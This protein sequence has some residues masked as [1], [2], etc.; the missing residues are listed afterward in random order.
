MKNNTLQTVK[1]NTL[2]VCGGTGAHVALALV[3]L[4]TL[5]HAL[6]F[7]RGADDQPLAFP[8]IYLV[9][10]DSGDG[11]REATAWQ[12]ARRLVDAHPGRHNWQEAIGRSD[13]PELKIVTPLPVGSNRSWFNPPFDTLGRRFAD[14]P[15]LD[16]LT[17]KAQRDVRFSHGMMGSPAVGS[18]LFRLKEFDTESSEAGTNH[19]GTYHKLLSTRGR[20]AVVGSAVG[21]TGASVAPTLA[22]RFAAAGDDVMAVMVLN[23][24][25]FDPEG[26]DEETLEKAQ[27]RDRSMVQ[28]ANSAF[29]YYGR[30]LAHRVAT[31]PVGMP[32]TV[33]KLRR[34]TSDTQQP[35]R[36]S[37]IHGVAALCGLH[38]FL[39]REPYSRGLYQMGAEDPTRL[40]GGNRLP[41]GEG[42]DTVQS[43]ANQAATLA[44]TLHVFAATLSAP[45][46]RGLFGVVP[47]IHEAAGRLAAPERVGRAVRDLAADYREHLKWMEEVLGVQPRPD[48]SLTSEARSRSRL[49][50]HKLPRTNRADISAEDSAALA[51]F[52]W[53]AHWIRDYS[54]VGDGR[55]ALVA[56][57]AL[58]V[59]GGYWPPL[60]GH[61]A[62]NVAAEKA[63][64]LTQVSD[65]DIDGTVEGFILEE[66]VS[67]NGWPDP[68]AAVDHFRYAIERGRRGH[69]TERRQLEMLLA[70]VVM[71]KLVLRD[72]PPRTSPPTL[73]LEQLVDESREGRLPDFAR[74]EVVYSP[75][76]GDVVLGFN[77]PYTLLCPVPT[78]ASDE[79][80]EGAWGALW[81]AL[82]GS[83]RPREWR[84][85][86]IGE[87][88]Y[89]GNAVRQI[90]A[91]I[92][93]EKRVRGGTPL[94]WTHVF[95]H[96]SV[97]PSAPFGRGR[98]LSVHW[99]ADAEAPIQIALPT[100]ESGNYWPDEDT[101]PI[102]EA[103]L[104]AQAPG[105]LTL[106]T[107]AGIT[108]DRV[109]FELPDRDAPVRAL[110][111]EHLEHLQQTGGIAAFG[112]KPDD[113]QVAFLTA[114]RRSAAILDN[115]I[116]LDRDDIMVRDCSPMRQEPV[117]GS[118]TTDGR[119]HYPDYPLR[120]DY[121]GL[122]ETDE[123]RRVVDL[124]KHGEQVRAAQPS[125]DEGPRRQSTDER[126]HEPPSDGPWEQFGR[127]VR[128][129]VSAARR[130][131]DQ[132]TRS[133]SDAAQSSGDDIDDGRRRQAAK[134]TWNLRLAGRSD[135]LPITLQVP[136]AGAEHHR[137][138]WMVWPRFRSGEAPFWRAYYVYEHC[139][140]VRL[141][142]STLW[143]DPDDGC[144]R[145]CPTPSATGAHP[146]RFAAGDRRAHTG[147]PPLAFSV[148]N[149]ESGQELGLYVIHLESLPRRHADVKL[150]LDFGTS[151]TVASVQ[152]DGKKHLVELPP[153][154]AAQRRDALTLH[155]SENWLHVKDAFENDGLQALGIWLPTYTDEAVQ[156][157][158]AGL[159]PSELLT[160]RP[161]ASLGANDVAQWEPGRDCVI[162]LMNMRRRN[163]AEHLLSDFKWDASFPAFRGRERVLRE[164]YLGMAIELVM[165]DVVRRLHAMPARADFTFTYPLRTPPEQRES[166]ERTLRRVM[167]S[168]TR[169][170]GFPFGLVDDIGIYNESSAA[171]GGTRRFGEVCLVG[172]LGGGTLDLFISAYGAPGVDFEEVADSA[173]IG[174]NELLRTMAEHPDRF[175]PP[176]WADRPGDVQTQLRAWMRSKGAARLFG[177]GTGEAERHDGLDVKGF[178]KPAAAKA[179]RALIERYFRLIVEYMARSL[180]AYLVRHWYSQ[181]L[182][183]RP[184]SHDELRVLVQL[185]GNGWR[186]WHS[187]DQYAEIKEKIAADIGARASELWRDRAGDRDA[188]RGQQELW[189]Q[190]SLWT[191]PDGSDHA[192]PAV[193][194]P[195]CSPEGSREP[196]PKAAPILR[197]VGRAQPHAEIRC[198]SHALVELALL[199]D[200]GP[201]KDG[202]R[203]RIR[204]FDRLPVRTGG[205]GVKVEFHKV[206]PPFSL[207]HPTAAQKRQLKDLE[208]ELKH[209][210]NQQLEELGIAS[211]V[212]FNAPIA[213]LVWEAA[214]ESRQF[215]QGE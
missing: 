4:H 23:W 176:G 187:T 80:R 134:A 198:Y 108:F 123:G 110:W 201:A 99:G 177:D 196:N 16:L 205:G 146:L 105:V 115:V 139:T 65:Q 184:G 143:L 75:P 145:R 151:H 119:I 48:H 152:A 24:F 171:K 35:I 12:L 76:D 17:S 27:L 1:N 116:V 125:I 102:A 140:D 10:Q 170:L 21:G 206:E 18:L 44:E 144:V 166:Y 13:P 161:L 192:G 190:H 165:A 121:L 188:W 40:G 109:E 179:A 39:E 202:A 38:H 100:A 32:D 195:T 86:E 78:A 36:E 149:S 199:G 172:D 148:Q 162:P 74:V 98:T 62:R 70:G 67:Q 22:Q 203:D 83:R 200:R 50:E 73:S 137:A 142:L 186:L 8:T 26:L 118:S 209:E 43:L 68:M 106:R 29:A 53:T 164:I 117:P 174:G 92:E 87:W 211:E 11:A 52:R 169:S 77:S 20:V 28:N 54:R 49:A 84:T 56:P 57:P 58:S 113:R 5:G 163:L 193:G 47:A 69:P 122:V 128:A 212:D 6:G 178:D 94:P 90:R 147:G 112:A 138:H 61:D 85:E 19:D 210:I 159:L 131:L 156:K 175:L 3:R 9:D 204:W 153:E 208:P 120:S 97:S 25:R 79:V 93:S 103:E 124:L 111:R 15:Y 63:G 31:V 96:E 207:S 55:A 81:I 88:R 214:F 42:D 180:V 160:I 89:A 189:R 60:V 141:H 127:G 183:N 59:R 194:A 2:I 136:Q 154:F 37:F 191:A 101:P 185:R 173:K 197:V 107:D 135:M 95:E 132:F 126:S 41:G 168:S 51:L 64:R 91:W 66:H 155:V 213:A 14:S 182:T 158:T 167:E 215:V 104:L 82:T 33:I 114:D 46:G 7:F 150:G 129:G 71:G 72:V 30:T 157:E 34:Y 133:E 130:T 181:V 45:Q